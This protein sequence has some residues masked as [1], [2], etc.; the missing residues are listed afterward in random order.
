MEQVAR[1]NSAEQHEDLR[2][3]QQRRGARDDGAEPLFGLLQGARHA[4]QLGQRDAGFL[5]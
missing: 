4:G 3:N 2:D 5:C 1:G